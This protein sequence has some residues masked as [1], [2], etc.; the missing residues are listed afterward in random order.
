MKT[1][2]SSTSSSS[3]SS[4]TASST[5]SSSLPTARSEATRAMLVAQASG[6]SLSTSGAT[7]IAGPPAGRRRPQM[8]RL[9]LSSAFGLA[10]TV[11][12]TTLL[13]SDPS[14]PPAQAAWSAVP[15]PAPSAG[16]SGPSL[17][18]LKA[19]CDGR[20]LGL[21]RPVATSPVADDTDA[22]R[23]ILVDR[24]GDFVFCVVV[25]KS[26]GSKSDPFVAR[27][28]LTAEK[29]REKGMTRGTSL[30]SDKP[31]PRPPADGILILGGD[32]KAP[33]A[34]TAIPTPGQ[35]EKSTPDYDLYKTW[36]A[37]QLYGFA[38]PEVTGIDVVLTNGLRI[39]ATVHDGL[40]GVWWPR[41]MGDPAGSRLEVRTRNGVQ[42]V[43]PAAVRLELR[44]LG[45]SWMGGTR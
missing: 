29:G 27:A 10:V 21:G 20:V 2:A 11:G 37:S 16:A 31:V 45:Y 22:D 8:R 38:G 7:V 14:S 17:S 6:D 19:R 39:T 13:I 9:A 25:A 15:E 18:L 4:S 5:L 34:H 26:R 36:F 28:G 33:T 23:Q 3:P 42:T 43:D 44:S 40:W 12:A 24:R 32:R 1:T 30:W 41:E 35:T